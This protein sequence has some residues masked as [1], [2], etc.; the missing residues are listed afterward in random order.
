M[1]TH[2][3][4]LKYLSHRVLKVLDG[5]IIGE[6]LIDSRIREEHTNALR[7][8][9]AGMNEKEEGGQESRSEQRRV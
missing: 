9:L 2:D 1:V 6:E 5:K 8:K 4:N 7:Q 3:V